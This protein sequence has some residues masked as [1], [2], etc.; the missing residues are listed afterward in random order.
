[1]DRRGFI[2][3]VGRGSMLAA[4]AAVAGI[5]VARKQVQPGQECSDGF[6]CREC[7]ILSDCQLPEAITTRDHGEKG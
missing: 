5:L 1:M 7:R 6:R 3:K 4:L 2:Q